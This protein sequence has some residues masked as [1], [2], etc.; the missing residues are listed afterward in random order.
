VQTRFLRKRLNLLERALNAENHL[1][2][3]QSL[4]SQHANPVLPTATKRQPDDQRQAPREDASAQISDTEMQGPSEAAHPKPIAAPQPVQREETPTN[5][6]T[7]P[8]QPVP[9]T[10]NCTSHNNNKRSRRYLILTPHSHRS[11]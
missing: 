1:K 2:E 3:L 4:R 11:I 8:A 6:E 5:K 7:K 9:A 10:K